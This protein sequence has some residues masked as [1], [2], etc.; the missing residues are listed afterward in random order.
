MPDP[1][2]M[3]NGSLDPLDK[4]VGA[5]T[6]VRDFMTESDV[7]LD[8]LSE[9]IDDRRLAPEQHTAAVRRHNE[10]VT[11]MEQLAEEFNRQVRVFKAREN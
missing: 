1:P 10:M 8:C 3:P 2:A 11:L 7:Y 6:A 9:I 4:M 5:Q